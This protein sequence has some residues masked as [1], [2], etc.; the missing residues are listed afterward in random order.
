[1]LARALALLAALTGPIGA[2]S[3]RAQTVGGSPATVGGE[4]ALTPQEAEQV[5]PL[6][7]NSLA[8]RLA[9]GD[10]GAAQA[11][12]RWW[13]R[14]DPYPATPQ[15]ERVDEH[16]RRVE[17]ALERYAADT[18]AGYD[19]RGET[20]VR[21]GPPARVRVVDYEANLFIARKIREEP[22]VRRSDFPRNETW[23]YPSLDAYYVFYETPDGYREGTP[24]NLIP[25]QLQAGGYSAAT[26]SRA[27][28]LGQVIRQIHKDLFSFDAQIRQRLSDIDAQIGGDGAVLYDSNTRRQTGLVLSGIVQRTRQEDE[29]V[30]MLRNR[31]LPASTSGGPVGQIAARTARFLD[32]PVEAP[33]GSVWVGWSQLLPSQARVADS[34][35][36]E[37]ASHALFLIE[38]VGLRYDADIRLTGREDF[39][40]IVLP[41]GAFSEPQWTVVQGVDR[42][43][44][45][46]FQWDVTPADRD[47]VPLLGAPI[48]QA[49]LRMPSLDGL[50]EPGATVAVSDML[51][52]AVE[53]IDVALGADR[54][55]GLPAPHPYEVVPSDRPLALYYE[56]Y[57]PEA[58]PAGVSVRLDVEVT[59]RRDGRLLR[60]GQ[61]DRSTSGLEFT[62]SGG[63]EPQM[64]IVEPE[65][66]AGAD[67]VMVEVTLTRLS[68][69]ERVQREATFRV[70]QPS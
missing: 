62:L 63:R 2:Q 14:Q 32:G 19:V 59:R 34:L 37:A 12:A 70:A 44:E 45:A 49:V 4:G 47:G 54:L 46:A 35:G 38:A 15:N 33:T 7:P 57:G 48:S 11:V 39:A 22:A 60:A 5:R 8:E 17:A 42:E 65:S 50:V 10:A 55:D 36:A 16:R 40:F 23:H 6:L 13:R 20:L 61:R 53:S 29:R 66:L 31:R 69:G 52:L 3:V 1:M 24:V 64:V 27:Q 43:G 41:G 25:R 18:P 9:R 58:A 56:I 28:L 51:P 26:E 67:E 21:F 30:R 68:S